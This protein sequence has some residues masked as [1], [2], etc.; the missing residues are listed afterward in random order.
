MFI[1]FVMQVP[2]ANFTVHFSGHL[3]CASFVA[4]IIEAVLDGANFP[5]KVSAHWHKVPN[6]KRK[7]LMLFFA[8]ILEQ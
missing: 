1:C 5:V 4:G 6:P 3:N 8:D 2:L 7:F